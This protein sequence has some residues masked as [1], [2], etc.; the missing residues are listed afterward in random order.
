MI[1][2]S[3]RATTVD[4]AGIVVPVSPRTRDR[5]LCDAECLGNLEATTPKRVT[6]SVTPRVRRQVLARDH[7]RCTVP[8]CRATHGLQIHHVDHQED[9][10]SHEPRNQTT[11]CFTHHQLHHAEKLAIRRI[12]HTVIFHRILEHGDPVQE[13]GTYDL[14]GGGDEVSDADGTFLTDH[15]HDNRIANYGP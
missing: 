2:P 6:S 9:G 8:G 10:G 1:C 14:I 12:G 13:L 11:L 7:H 15:V 3:C 4:G 5:A